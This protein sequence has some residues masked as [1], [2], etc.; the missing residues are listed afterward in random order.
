VTTF[1]LVRQETRCSTKNT[2]PENSH[3]SWR[4]TAVVWS[5]Q[6]GPLYW[7]LHDTPAFSLI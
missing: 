5:H 7:R 2:V 3:C 4:C 1:G 6:H